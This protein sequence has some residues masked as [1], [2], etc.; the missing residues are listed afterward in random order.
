MVCGLLPFSPSSL[1]QP[2]R[3]VPLLAA[4]CR[5]RSVL[6][7][8]HM[9]TACSHTRGRCWATVFLLF[10]RCSFEAGAWAEWASFQPSTVCFCMS[11]QCSCAYRPAHAPSPCSSVFASTNSTQSSPSPPNT[12]P[13]PTQHH[14]PPSQSYQAHTAVS[15]TLDGDVCVTFTPLTQLRL[16]EPAFSPH[17]ELLVR[18]VKVWK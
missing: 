18:C 4:S 10:P 3:P 17:S 5:I 13:F 15:H 14:Q 1:P 12:P 16:V 2:T 9:H 11:C 6:R 8:L 7:T